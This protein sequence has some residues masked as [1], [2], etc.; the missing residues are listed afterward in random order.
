[1]RI[2]IVPRDDYLAH[3]GIKW[4]RW[5]V[6]RYQNKDG[7]LTAEGRSHYNVGPKRKEARSSKR[8]SREVKHPNK[9]SDKVV[10]KNYKNLS[11][12]ELKKLT[13]RLKIENKFLEQ[14]TKNQDY[15]KG[16]TK[17]ER[18]IDGLKKID[19][20]TRTTK[21]IYMSRDKLNELKNKKKS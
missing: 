3:H 12:K 7:S 8:I 11:D 21:N 1:M 19:E 16:K 15:Y 17:T 2:E 20:I 14:V 18:V 9:K 6:R 13:E 5:G 4:Q 10:K